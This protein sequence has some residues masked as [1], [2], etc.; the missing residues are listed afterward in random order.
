MTDKNKYAPQT[1]YKKKNIKRISFDFN[2]ATEADLIEWLEKQ[3]NKAGL[4]KR[5]LREEME[6]GGE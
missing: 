3:P 4:I 6:K 1:K 2:Y 5:L